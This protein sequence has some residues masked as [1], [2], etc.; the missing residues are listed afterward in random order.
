MQYWGKR[1]QSTVEIKCDSLKEYKSKE[2]KEILNEL[3]DQGPD[4]VIIKISISNGE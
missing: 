1:I 2:F 4:Q 3:V